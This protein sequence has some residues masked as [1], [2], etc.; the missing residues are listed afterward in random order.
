MSSTAVTGAIRFDG[1][2]KDYP[3]ADGG[4]CA[5][6][7]VDLSIAPGEFVSIVGPSGCGKS[8]L[9]RMLAGFESPDR[10]SVTVEGRPVDGPD[11]RRGVVF[12]A[13]TLYPWLTVRRNVEYGLRARRVPRRTRRERAEEALDLVGLEGFGERRPY[14][15]SGGMQQRAQIARVLVTEPEMLLMDEPFGALDQLTRERMQAEFLRLHRG[16]GLTTLFV[17]H[18]VEEA[19]YLSTRVVVMSARP[20]RVILDLPV[21]LP[22]DGDEPRPPSVTT[23]ARFQE[24]RARVTEAIVDAHSASPQTEHPVT[25]APAR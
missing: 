14:E 22:A 19:V 9:L 16:R 13:P 8:T 5:L 20:G 18:S 6:D 17:T 3:T 25:G 12:Q 2:A 21:D 23:S 1:V 15:L 7:G 4:V 11:P 24:L 10:G